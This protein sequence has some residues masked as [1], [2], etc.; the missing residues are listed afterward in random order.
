VRVKIRDS[1]REITI[2]IT[3]IK[4]IINI[5]KIQGVINIAG[6]NKYNKG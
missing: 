1:I 6:Y 2:K 4:N 3:F 5:I